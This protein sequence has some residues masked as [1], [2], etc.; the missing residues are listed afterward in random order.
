M[1]RLLFLM[2]LSA[3][4]LTLFNC[5]D[6]EEA[7]VFQIY[8]LRDTLVKR[9]GKVVMASADGSISELWRFFFDTTA[10]ADTVTVVYKGIT[11]RD[12][13]LRVAGRVWPTFVFNVELSMPQPS[14]HHPEVA[15][16]ITNTM[17]N[18]VAEDCAFFGTVPMD[19]EHM[20]SMLR[21]M[22]DCCQ[23]QMAADTITSVPLPRYSFVEM[24]GT[25]PLMSDKILTYR[26]EV[27]QYKVGNVQPSH[28]IKYR[29]FDLT[30]G[31]S[32][33]EE[34]I[35]EMTP[36]NRDA[37][38][39]LLREAFAGLRHS[40]TS[41]TYSQNTVWDFSRMVMNGNFGIRKHSLVYYYNGQY[42]PIY[43]AKPLE[44]EIMSYKLEPYMKKNTTLY[45]YWF[46]KKKVL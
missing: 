32:L 28:M 29:V 16:R 27:N 42:S 39:H 7:T 41:D 44:L 43:V 10:A 38:N 19:E 30:D 23:A 26:L 1:K 13:A 33:H 22:I 4:T 24:N 25:T 31:S 40:D 11:S 45:D 8:S 35:F 3:I 2:V 20:V 12:S 21:N 6:N 18:V 34:D 17:F 9:D 37:I 15:Q 14:R 5:S 46:N 36:A